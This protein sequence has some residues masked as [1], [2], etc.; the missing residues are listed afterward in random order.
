MGHYHQNQMR[1]FSDHVI[2]HQPQFN[3]S[4][5]MYVENTHLYTC[6]P[7][8]DNPFYTNPENAGALSTGQPQV[9]FLP[10][11]ICEHHVAPSPHE[12]QFNINSY[13]L[14]EDG[15]A[16]CRVAAMVT[17]CITKICEAPTNSCCCCNC[18]SIESGFSSQPSCCSACQCCQSC[19]CCCN[20]FPCYSSCCFQGNCCLYLLLLIL[21]FYFAT[22]ILPMPWGSGWKIGFGIY[23][24]IQWP[25]VHAASWIMTFQ[26]LCVSCILFT[27]LRFA[28]R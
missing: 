19:C 28:R 11:T 3:P 1:T 16:L 24:L 8:V 15:E 2:R 13:T 14:A 23:C 5:H 6:I 18:L 17:G 21:V 26:A 20:F 27:P 12:V 10:C 7:Q 9:Y 4:A 25:L 22:K